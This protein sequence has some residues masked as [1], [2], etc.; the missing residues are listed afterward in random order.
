MRGCFIIMI[1]VMSNSAT[2][3]RETLPARSH[4]ASY[5]HLVE[6][7]QAPI[8][9]GYTQDYNQGYSQGYT[10]G[11]FEGN[12]QMAG[13]GLSSNY[14]PLGRFSLCFDFLKFV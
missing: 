11:Y 12:N 1:M 2:L 5:N 4:N 6:L 13:S 8:T 10:H 9:P 7:H 3:R 14:P